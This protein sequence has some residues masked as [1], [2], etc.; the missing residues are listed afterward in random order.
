MPITN[1]SSTR[2]FFRI[3]FY[4][5]K[6][7]VIAFFLMVGVIV[8]YAYTATPIYKSTAKILVLPKTNQDL[9]ISPE[10][11]K[12]QLIRPVS[13]EDINTEVDILL[14]D[15]VISETVK[16]L[17]NKNI[18]LKRRDRGL[19][20]TL[21]DNIKSGVSQLFRWLKL[22]GDPLPPFEAQVALLKKSLDVEPGYNASII[23]VTL[24]AEHAKSSAAILNR[25]LE[26]YIKR[27]N[28]VFTIDEGLD[29]YND[30]AEIYRQKLEDAEKKIKVFQKDWRIVNLD[31]QNESN[32]DLL[33]EFN[34]E[35]KTIEI[36]YDEAESKIVMLKKILNSNPKEIIF[37]KEMRNIPAIIEL[38]RGIIPLLIKRS[39]IGTNYTTTSR[40]YIDIVDQIEML[41]G[42][43]RKEV[44]KAIQTDELELESLR[45][46]KESLDN[47]ISELQLEASELHQKE[48]KLLELQRE[49]NLHKENYVLYSGK[50]EDARMYNE[51]K[52]RGLA[53]VSIADSA[54]VPDRPTSPNRILLVGIS[55]FL[56]FFAAMCMPFILEV[57]DHK[58]KTADD[59]EKLL[60]LP[61]VCSLPELKN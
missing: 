1:L 5:K 38:E 4:W 16:S 28:D 11:N 21:I 43:V 19:F 2:D 33:T 51:R 7:A 30:Q 15:R 45:I 22:I 60:D 17:E 8:F 56:G 50:T 32:I 37:T 46:K 34:K 42:E 48:K 29:F 44:G 59:V 49:V 53:N 9:V 55:L 25:L 54:N 41:R 31:R 39:E 47:K 3:L 40:E 52:N 27:H 61:V 10:D 35:L 18:G 57:L 13:E 14:S 24:R 12:R 23:Y 26:V 36:A 58:L 20:D 6:Q